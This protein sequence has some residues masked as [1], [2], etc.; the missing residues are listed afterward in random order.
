[1]GLK[2]L[3]SRWSK[4][5]DERAIDRA[6]RESRMS[7]TERAFDSEDFEGRKDDVAAESSW[8]GSEAIDAA[9][10]DVDRS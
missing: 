2:A 5:E 1:M 10:D 4:G 9:G 7:P 3:F 8:A 6:E